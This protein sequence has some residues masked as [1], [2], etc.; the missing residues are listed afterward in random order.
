MYLIATTVAAAFLL[1]HHRD[2]LSTMFLC[3][4][5]GGYA[6]LGECLGECSVF[7]RGEDFGLIIRPPRPGLFCDGSSW[8]AGSGRDGLRGG[9]PMPTAE[10]VDGGGGGSGNDDEE[11]DDGWWLSWRAEVNRH[12]RPKTR[13]GKKA[14]RIALA[15]KTM[16]PSKTRKRTSAWATSL[17]KPSAITTIRKAVRTMKSNVAAEK[18]ISVAIRLYTLC[19][20]I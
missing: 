2:S 10:N 20:C 15:R 19:V 16:A 3:E 5:G 7:W 18:P 6:L 13:L 8:T 14:S 4:G 17:W 12:E 11:Y 1:V 9:L